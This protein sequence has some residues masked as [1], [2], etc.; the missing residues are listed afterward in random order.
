MKFQLKKMLAFGGLVWTLA[1]IS[2]AQTIQ[3]TMLRLPDTGQTQ[4]F[5]NTLGEDADYI[6]N[7][8][9]FQLNGD[10][11]VTDTVT[12]LMWQQTDGGEMTIE[13]A[14]TFC[15][16]LLLG[17]HDDWRLP[18]A[19]EAY[20]IM[21]QGKSDPALDVSIF[22]NTGAEYWWT[23]QQD[24]TNG[25]K[26]WVTNKG[27]GIGNHL[28]TETV[29][30]GGTKKIH[31]R[32]VRDVATPSTVSGHF[33]DNGDG[34]V[35]D[36][37][38]N[39]VWAKTPAPDSMTW[40]N[41]LVFAENFSL[42]GQDDWRLPNI[43][44]LESLSD[45]NI[46]NP[47]VNTVFF[48]E[49]GVKKYWSGTTLQNQPARAW[50]LDTRF[51]ITTYT[52]KT[53]KSNL[54]C[55]RSNDNLPV[56][57]P[58]IFHA[59]MLFR[60]TDHSI[61]VQAFLGVDAEICAQFGT[62]SGNLIQ[63]TAW[64]SVTSDQAAEILIGG[65]AADTRYFYRL[66]YKLPGPGAMILRPEH[67]FHTQ[68]IAGS[69]FTFVVQADPHLDVASDSAL[70]RRC[71]QNQL[72]D[73]PDFMIDL[74][75]FLMSDKLKNTQGKITR[76]TVAYR[77][78]LLR[79]FYET[80]C[81]SV[82]L[83]IA[84]GNH[85]GESG[86]QLNGTDQ[87]VAI[88]GA[89]ERKKYFRNPAPDDFY[90]GDE[91]QNQFV[92]QRENY[93]SWQWGD[94]Q[95]IVLDPYWYTSPKPDSLHGWRWTLG[96][97]QYDWLKNTLETSTA[98]FKFVFA[99]QLV[100]GDPLGRG[101]VEFAD[102]YEWGGQNLDDTDGWTANRPGWA[103]PIK[104][105]LTENRVT[106][107]FHGHDHFFGKQ[108]KD[109]LIYQETPQPSLPNFTGPNQA[110]DYGYFSGQFLPNTGHIRVTVGPDGVR[111]E[112]IRAFLPNQETATRHN[113][114]IAATYFIGKTNCYDSLSTG[115][116]V[117]WNSNYSDEL[118]YPN[119]SSGDVQIKFS[120]AKA[121]RLNLSIF[122][123]NGRLVRRMLAGNLVPAGNFELVWDGR[124]PG[125]ERLPGG[126]YFWNISG[127]SGGTAA[128]RLILQK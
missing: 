12:G 119:P 105:L 125:G 112:Y 50:H 42:A 63:Q 95:F 54:I 80:S 65:L 27:G 47:S 60:P 46:A 8:P 41:A 44:E 1:E 123:G 52:E 49:I 26:I 75:D 55:V 39:L 72:A 115:T 66:C 128:G 59:E 118:V 48:P 101:G 25:N 4:S 19:Q 17:G 91:T 71:L 37:L 88:F 20:S 70:Y 94:A 9:F 113:G 76:D 79:S 106:T 82:P 111:T 24:A 81:H 90:T 38:T 28:K 64:K 78:H 6:Q 2:T 87:N 92:G 51:G 122:D 117:L 104:D 73:E 99:H 126:V 96:K 62:E 103:K 84:L 36:N 114:D 124:G 22:T 35:T 5:T 121:E 100:G 3:K 29:S 69:T 16:N 31:V 34:T 11:T 61:T 56:M 21:N 97:T 107:F 58:N 68:R 43:K 93:Y 120:L 53:G 67:A 109:C 33:S 13:N 89:T 74:G 127:E 85:E 10:G 7:P 77:C 32:A 15:E 102:R 108:E 18:T 30:A 83:F 98:T 40:E 116:P 110:D 57:P 23:S 86:W 14:A 45:A